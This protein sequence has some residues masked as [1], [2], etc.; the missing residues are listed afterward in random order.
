MACCY[1]DRQGDYDVESVHNQRQTASN[2][3]VLR[4]DGSL[5][6]IDSWN[7][8]LDLYSINLILYA[9]R[10]YLLLHYDSV[11]ATFDRYSLDAYALYQT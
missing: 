9:S 6:E 5:V 7:F 11:P 3:R 10:L 4:A 1:S 8:L 2:D